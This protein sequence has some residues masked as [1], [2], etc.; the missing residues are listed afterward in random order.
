MPLNFYF[1][2]LLIWVNFHWYRPQGA[3]VNKSGTKTSASGSVTSKTGKKAIG[4]G[5]DAVAADM[6]QERPEKTP[7]AKPKAKSQA[8]PKT[9]DGSKK[10]Q[11]D[12]KALL[13]TNCFPVRNFIL[14]VKV[15]SLTKAARQGAEGP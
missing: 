8:R 11:K 9:E 6:A 12:I 3:N 14:L 4:E 15:S 13:I 7:R 10:L 5:L 2:M 1:P